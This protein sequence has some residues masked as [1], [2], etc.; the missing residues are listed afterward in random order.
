M[1]K[2][3][4]WCGQL[5]DQ[6]QLKNRTEQQVFIGAVDSTDRINFSNQQPYSAVRL[7]RFHCIW[8]HTAIQARREHFPP[9]LST[10][11]TTVYLFTDTQAVQFLYLTIPS[12]TCL[13]LSDANFICHVTY[14]Q[15]PIQSAFFPCQQPGSCSVARG[16]ATIG[17]RTFLKINYVTDRLTD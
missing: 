12:I 16:L 2:V 8:R 6:G 17:H 7:D 3:R 4:S 5:L 15:F 1:E 9:A 10:G 13:R 14:F 11:D